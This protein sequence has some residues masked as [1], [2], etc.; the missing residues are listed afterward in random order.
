MGDEAT[1]GIGH[2]V[3]QAT[4]LAAV[5]S[6]GTAT[7]VRVADEALAAVGHAQRT[8]HKELQFASLGIEHIMDG[9]DLRQG[10]LTGQHDLREAHVLHELCLF[11]RANVGLRAGMQLD[12][13]E[14]H[15]QQ[16]HVLHDQY[17]RACVVHVPCH[18]ACGFEL[19]VAQNRVEG[20]EDF[21]VEAMRFLAQAF[22]V[23]QCIGGTGAC[24]KG[25]GT[26]VH[27]VCAVVNGRNANVGITR[28]GQQFELVVEQGHTRII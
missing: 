15:F 13:G 26:D 21:A 27:R 4:S 12:W 22:N 8:V 11:R 20:D 24:T 6:V 17:I 3:R 1:L 28:R 14:V 23:L 25:G 16:T 2:V 5:T 9:F 19:V 10:Q 18:L 7:C